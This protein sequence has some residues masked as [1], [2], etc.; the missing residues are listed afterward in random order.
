MITPPKTVLF[1]TGTFLSNDCWNEWKLYFEEQGYKCIAPA[2]PRKEASPEELRNRQPNSGI[3]AN[4]LNDIVIFFA[5]I[6]H[7][8]PEKP[9]L[10]G[11]SMGGLIVQLL[12]Q[13]KLGVKGV[14]IHSFPPSGTATFRLLRINTWRKAMGLF[15]SVETDYMISFRSWKYRIANGMDCDDQKEL[16]YKYAIPESKLLVRDAFTGS[17]IDFGNPHPPLLLTS[18]SYDKIIPPSVNYKNYR[19]YSHENSITAYREFK[20]YNH[21]MFDKNGWKEY[22]DFVLD[23]LQKTN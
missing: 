1:I 14:A 17:G 9:I 6:I 22:A 2:W 21:L 23:W 15:S 19:K 4:R 20:Y 7:T 13:Q 3:S 18:G 16:Y 5:G 12:L 10:I 8:L 11:H